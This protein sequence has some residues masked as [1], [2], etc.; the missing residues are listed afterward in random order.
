MYE[1]TTKTH[2]FVVDLELG[3]VREWLDKAARAQTTEHVTWSIEWSRAETRETD[4]AAPRAGSPYRIARAQRA[5]ELR[6]LVCTR[7]ARLDAGCEAEIAIRERVDGVRVSARVRTTTPREP[8][9]PG[10]YEDL[11][12]LLAA[13]FHLALGYFLLVFGAVSGSVIALFGAGLGALAGYLCL[14]IFKSSGAQLDL[15]FAQLDRYYDRDWWRERYD[16]HAVLEAI[17]C[18]RFGLDLTSAPV[19]LQRANPYAD[20]IALA[21]AEQVARENGDVDQPGRADAEARF[22]R[23][24]LE[25]NAAL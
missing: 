15:Y 7:D 22:T 6:A 21:F 19:S 23:R 14:R 18:H 3:V 5:Q 16:V 25:E 24:F 11:I 1:T 17:R 20:P 8:S 9:P 12:A 4:A 10:D 13:Y 2:D